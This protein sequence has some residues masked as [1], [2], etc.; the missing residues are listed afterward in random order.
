MFSSF[1]GVSQYKQV[2]SS[3][4]SGQ[5]WMRQ[6]LCCCASCLAREWGNCALKEYVDAPK[7]VNLNI[8]LNL[9]DDEDVFNDVE[10]TESGVPYEVTDLFHDNVDEMGDSVNTPLRQSSLCV[11]HQDHEENILDIGSVY[12]VQDGSVTGF[13]LYKCCGVTPETGIG[14]A[15]EI[16]DSEEPNGFFGLTISNSSCCFDRSL[17]FSTVDI[18]KKGIRKSVLEGLLLF[19]SQ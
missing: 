16:S 5:L 17:V 15:I 4:V 13:Q 9:E 3:T 18:S 1:I 19:V 7:L 8:Q 2:F 11:S 12:A 6:M 14:R 10:V